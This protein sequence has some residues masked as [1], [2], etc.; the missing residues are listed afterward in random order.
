MIK[1]IV[2][3]GPSK[4]TIK[5]EDQKIILTKDEYRELIPATKNPT[6]FFK[7]LKKNIKNYFASLK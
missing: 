1:T 5:Y 7:D 6:N 2:T 4:V 3:I